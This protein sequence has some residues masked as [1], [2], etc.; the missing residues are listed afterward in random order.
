MANIGL[1]KEGFFQKIV[2]ILDNIIVIIR[3]TFLKHFYS[4]SNSNKYLKYMFYAKKKKKEV[5]NKENK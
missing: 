1:E 2:V 4:W 5:K 3:I